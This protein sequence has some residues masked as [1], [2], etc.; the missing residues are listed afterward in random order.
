M[1]QTFREIKLNRSQAGIKKRKIIFL[2]LFLLIFS[3]PIFYIVNKQF[4]VFSEFSSVDFNFVKPSPTEIPIKTITHFYAPVVKFTDSRSDITLEEIKSSQLVTISENVDIFLDG[5]QAD[6]VGIETIPEELELGKIAILQ[7]DQITPNFKTLSVEGYNLWNENVDLDKY[8]LTFTEKIP[9]ESGSEINFSKE[10]ISTIF[11]GGEIIPARAVDRLGLNVHD[12]YTY[13]FDFVRQ[14]IEG[15]DLAI[16][17]LENPLMG[18]PTPCTGCTVFVGDEKNAK[19]FSEVGF[20]I[21]AFSGNHAGDG[22][23]KAYEPT[24]KALTD[25]GLKYTGVGKGVDEQMKPALFDINGKVIGMISADDVS[26]FYWSSDKSVYGVNTFSTSSNGILNINMQ[27]V[28]MIKSIKE[29]NN[30][31][32]LIIYESWGVEYTNRANSHQVELAHAFIDNGADLVVASH[33]HWVQ[34]IEFYK[35]KPIFYALGNFIFDQTH[36]LPT[37]QSV[38]ANLNYYDGVLGNIEIIPLQTC[39]YH[40]TKNDLTKE[41]L[42]GNISLEQL[43]NKPESEGCVWWQPRKVSEDTEEYKQILDRLFEFSTF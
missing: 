3:I 19:G 30:I 42:D 38:V 32:Y 31:D 8:P 4:V 33:P 39:G 15:A 29:E 37:R 10:A 26:Y 13:L 16:A 23:Q 36:T 9:G 34:N 2:I 14:N 7:I 17:Q 21:L 1:S 22:G 25:A 18:D 5:Y 43:Q 12:N 41:Y 24:I 6:V 20:D 35:G 27:K 40:Q 11:V 28:E